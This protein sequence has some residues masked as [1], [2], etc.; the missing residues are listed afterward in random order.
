MTQTAISE[1][2][3]TRTSYFNVPSEAVIIDACCLEDISLADVAAF[4]SHYLTTQRVLDEIDKWVQKE[5]KPL[6]FDKE[7]DTVRP[8][9]VW[10]IDECLSLDEAQRYNRA[11][12]ISDAKLDARLTGLQELR[13][14]NRADGKK[15]FHAVD[16]LKYFKEHVD[17]I[18]R[19]PNGSRHGIE[20]YAQLLTKNVIVDALDQHANR[21]LFREGSMK[22]LA[23]KCQQLYLDRLTS[24]GIDQ[25]VPWKRMQG[26]C[27]AFVTQLNRF[28]NKYN[29]RQGAGKSM[30]LICDEYRRSL[31]ND[32]STVEMAYDK[33]FAENKVCIYTKDRDIDDL[34]DYV[35]AAKSAGF[36]QTK[37]EVRCYVPWRKY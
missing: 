3:E 13:Q 28:A 32:V 7:K 18:V 24:M 37:N 8:G 31:Q 30:F 1:D 23:Q 4:P 35:N 20:K 21:E 27:N 36:L 25:Q 14:K 10:T 5:R 34:V 22:E 26:T 29:Q 33:R 11:N 6:S 16:G 19:T 15:F 12:G 9:Y 17:Q 2:L